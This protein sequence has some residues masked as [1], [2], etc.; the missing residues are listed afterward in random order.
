MS[1][2]ATLARLCVHG[3]FVTGSGSRLLIADYS[4]RLKYTEAGPVA[5][6]GAEVAAEEREGA[7][8]LSLKTQFVD[9]HLRQV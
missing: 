3:Q 4:E 5:F 2:G 7:F 1:G 6:A 9:Y 8:A